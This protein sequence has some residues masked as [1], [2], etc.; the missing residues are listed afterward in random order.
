[1]STTEFA[2]DPDGG[3][4]VADPAAVLR[5]LRRSASEHR[6]SLG[7]VVGLQG[8]GT[9]A[10]LVFPHELGIL[11]ASVAG[12][13][14][15]AGAVRRAGLVLLVALVVQ[16][17]FTRSASRRASVLGE[18]VLAQLREGFVDRVLDLPLGMVER[19]GTGELLTRASIDVE[20]VS[21]SIRYATPQVLVAVVQAALTVVAL[22]VT[23][24]V[25]AVV[26]VPSV[27]VL[28]VACR[29]YLRLAPAGYRRTQATYDRL[30][31]RFQETVAAGRTI[32]ALGLAAQRVGL[33]DDDISAWLATE[34]YTLG[35]RTRFYPVCEAAY[36]LPLVLTVAVGGWM[37]IGGHL[38]LASLTSAG[39]YASLLVVPVDAIVSQLDEVQ[40]ASASLARLLGVGEVPRRVPTDELPVGTEVV[41][42]NVHYSYRPGRD[43]LRGLDLA[44]VPGSTMALVGP[45]GAGK[46]TLALLIAGI[47]AP[48]H[49]R[50]TVGGVDTSSLPTDRLRQEVVLVTQEHHV[51]AG[52]FA[53][54]PGVG[55]TGGQ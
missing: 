23:A 6:R 12:G 37:S 9:A 38:D 47:H 14:D 42:S 55:L 29:W 19:A 50:V 8:L 48:T 49:G 33:A 52:T 7:A 40:L 53:R 34:R 32:E 27:V 20:Q 39:L 22:V 11:V 1:M 25:L 30:N 51:F 44:P 31:G 43:V 36:V 2:G 5:W 41:A 21:Y 26:L 3:F 17:V 18:T 4:P 15:P 16:A 45:S 24:P 35:L 13:S 46:S 10:A 54:Q 28:A